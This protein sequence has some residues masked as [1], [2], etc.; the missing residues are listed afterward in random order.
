M[1]AGRREEILRVALDMIAER[2]Y[3]GTSLDAIARSIG[4]TRQGVLHYFPG[5]QQLLAAI[6]ERTAELG[7]GELPPHRLQPDVPAQMAAVVAHNREHAEFAQAYSV[8]MAESAVTSHP[9]REHFREHY[10]QVLAEMTDSFTERWGERLPSGLTPHAAGVAVLAL[11][12][13]MQQQWLLD[14]DRT[15][16]P[17]IMQA[18]L[19]V[20]FGTG[21]SGDRP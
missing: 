8:L 9:A 12:D 3:R 17:E 18:V 7:R 15:D 2:G 20:L 21:S 19:T 11:L 13:G 16:D 14:R 1:S 4:L 6:L 10:R 5:K